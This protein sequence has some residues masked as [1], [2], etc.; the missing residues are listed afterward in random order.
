M[1]ELR[2]FLLQLWSPRKGES[3]KR[4]K[5]LF[6]NYPHFVTTFESGVTFHNDLPYFHAYINSSVFVTFPHF[7]IN[8]AVKKFASC[9]RVLEWCL[10]KTVC[11][12][13]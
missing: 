7:E 2:L 8:A 4:K 11:R 6:S 12:N 10:L 9:S 13:E 5:I 3:E 1:N